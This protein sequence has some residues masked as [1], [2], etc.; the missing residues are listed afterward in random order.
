[1]PCTKKKK[2]IHVIPDSQRSTPDGR[3]QLLPFIVTWATRFAHTTS[4][5]RQ[6]QG[7]H[8]SLVLNTLSGDVSATNGSSGR[9]CLPKNLLQEKKGGRLEF[10]G[11]LFGLPITGAP[12]LAPQINPFLAKK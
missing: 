6:H 7:Q 11:S 8:H 12:T 2:G 5:I 4:D 3:R 9:S 10:D 1:M